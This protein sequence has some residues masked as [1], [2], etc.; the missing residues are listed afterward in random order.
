MTHIHYQD[1][2]GIKEESKMAIREFPDNS[3][4]PIKKTEKRELPKININA[5]IK[6]QSKYKGAIINEDAG[7]MKDWLILDVLIPAGKK[8]VHDIVANGI[9]ILLYGTGGKPTGTRRDSNVSRISYRSYYDEPRREPLRETRN[10][11]RSD[12][13]VSSMREG[14]ELLSAAQDVIDMYQNISI[15]DLMELADPNIQT[16]YTDNYY[17][18]KDL[19]GARVVPVRDGYLVDMPRAIPLR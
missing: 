14:E 2:I 13:I 17:G 16:E 15:A 9:D 12:I 8:L 10:N 5:N 6:K 18:W 7:K 1:I 11:S 19:R 4:D 3:Q